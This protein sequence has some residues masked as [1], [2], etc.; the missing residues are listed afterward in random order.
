M[1]ELLI[2]LIAG[3][4]ILTSA[5]GGFNTLRQLF[6]RDTVKTDINQRLTIAFGSLGP[7]I[8]QAGEGLTNDV[9][10]PVIEV[11]NDADGSTITIRKADLIGFLPLC[12]DATSGATTEINIIDEPDNP[13]T[14]DP[15]VDCPASY[16]SDDD[17][18]PDDLFQWRQKRINAGGTIRAYIYDSVEESG[19]FIQFTGEETLNSSGA[20]IMVVD[21]DGT[22][23]P[24]RADTINM[25]VNADLD[26]TYERGTSVIYLLEER[27]YQ[28]DN[29]NDTFQ[30]TINDE[31]GVQTLDLLESIERMDI[32][33]AGTFIEELSNGTTI[34]EDY[35][36]T[37]VPPVSVSNDCEARDPNASLS[38]FDQPEEYNWSQIE[39]VDVTIVSEIPDGSPT[40][41]DDTVKI[42]DRTSL[43]KFTIRNRL[44]F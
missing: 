4:V 41:I 36:C 6:V 12:E 38:Q 14:P 1:L 7:D 18:F 33:I 30:L 24:V 11:T 23:P 5:L 32:S 20:S 26:T 42:E 13:T 22:D 15:L 44:S 8:Q 34:V 43:Q 35:Q 31:D 19:Q 29:T 28:V 3:S 40:N 25:L 21:G 2:G 17:G 16:A 10:F 9:N 37:I 27:T 39:S